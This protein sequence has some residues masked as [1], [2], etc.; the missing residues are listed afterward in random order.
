MTKELLEPFWDRQNV[1]FFAY[2]QT[3]AGK[4]HSMFGGIDAK[5]EWGVMPTVIDATL[6]KIQERCDEERGILMA[7]AVEFIG[8]THICTIAQN[9]LCINKLITY[10]RHTYTAGSRS[11]STLKQGSC[12][13]WI[14]RAR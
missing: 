4:T 13:W 10:I 12:A 2:G 6:R 7:S 14:P 8:F 5:K 1:H 3:G 11:I 9:C